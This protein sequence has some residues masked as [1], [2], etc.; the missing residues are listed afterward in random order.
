MR[1]AKENVNRREEFV[2]SERG[3]ETVYNDCVTCK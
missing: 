2:V 1:G 3:S